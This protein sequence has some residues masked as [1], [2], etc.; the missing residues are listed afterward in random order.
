MTLAQLLQERMAA[1]DL[2]LRGVCDATEV[3]Y[4]VLMGVR[5]RSVP[6]RDETVGPQRMAWRPER[7]SV[8][9]AATPCR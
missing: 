4:S 7:L 6:R 8:M 5:D 3:S 9:I 2:S 1:D